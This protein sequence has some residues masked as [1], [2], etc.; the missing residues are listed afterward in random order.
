MAYGNTH[1]LI[2]PNQ[3]ENNQVYQIYEG[4]LVRGVA[5]EDP[6]LFGRLFTIDDCRVGYF[7]SQGE[8]QASSGALLK[9]KGIIIGTDGTVTQGI[10][11]YGDTPTTQMEILDFLTN[12]Y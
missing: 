9:G 11:E 4:F 3:S 12:S 7:S 5:Q 8:V 6:P 2:D 10:F 1:G